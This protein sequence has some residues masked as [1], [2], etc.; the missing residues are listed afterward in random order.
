MFFRRGRGDPDRR[1]HFQKAAVDEKMT[2]A[3][4]EF[5]SHLQGLR[6]ARRMKDIILKKVVHID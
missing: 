4:N 5:G 6:L 2:D 3:L 1:V